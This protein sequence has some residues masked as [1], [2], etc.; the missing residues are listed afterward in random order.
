ML[1]DGEGG[2]PSHR[3]EAF[4]QVRSGLA[5]LALVAAPPPSGNAAEEATPG[6]AED[7]TVVA[8]DNAEWLDAVS[9][10]L[11]HQLVDARR[12][13]RTSMVARGKI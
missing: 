11:V 12:A 5:G 4:P 9:A 3:A 6:S 8:V 2:A 7:F 10:A 1:D 13:F